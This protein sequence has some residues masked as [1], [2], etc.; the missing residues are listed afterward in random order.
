MRRLR[1][2]PGVRRL[3][4]EVSLA[5]AN[6]VLP[7]FVRSGRD[8]RRPISSMPGHAQLSVDLIAKEAQT[9][10]SLGLGGVI[11]FGI[12]DDKDDRRADWIRRYAYAMH[13]AMEEGVD[14]RGFHYW[15]LLD[16]FE[17]A[18]GYDR[19]FGLYWVDF[20]TQSRIPKQSAFWYRQVARSWSLESASS[21][22]S[23]EKLQ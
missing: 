4:Q 3:T 13:R 10:Q 22:S 8:E 5:P 16:N 12:P 9:A 21:R 20:Q 11:L 19:R 23:S 2:H 15:S 1:Y 14:V 6:F 17:W 7:L 18:H